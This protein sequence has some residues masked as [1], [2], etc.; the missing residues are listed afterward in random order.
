MQTFVYNFQFSDGNI[1]S[2]P[3]PTPEI[4]EMDLPAWTK[5]EFHQCAHCPLSSATVSH[6]P[7]AV[8][9]VKLVGVF[10]KRHSY[11]TV[12]VN[13]DSAERRVTKS[14]T[15]QRALGSLLGLL[16]AASGCPKV[17]FL[18]PM[19]HFH[20]PFSTSKE[21]IYRVTSMY[22]LAQ[23]FV[24]QEN[25]TPDWNLG[26]LKTHYQELQPINAAMAKR[27]RVIGI[28]DGTV[29]ALVLLDLFAKAL[30]FSINE[31]LEELR[32]LFKK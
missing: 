2:F 31:A 4:Q 29:N 10:G 30:P 18:K 14:T 7:M 16:I 8:Q 20:L 9:L 26:G 11:D 21:T 15:V 28:E 19:A 27:L 5:L 24:V 32:P 23:Y 25:R 22:L 3:V 12:A 1:E 13:V 6:C 17:E